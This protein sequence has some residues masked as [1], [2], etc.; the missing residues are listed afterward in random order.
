MNS[1]G[2]KQSLSRPPLHPP[3]P[4]NAGLGARVDKVQSVQ[5]ER[6]LRQHLVTCLQ[7]ETTGSISFAIE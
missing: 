4:A 3:P 7:V 2:S 6:Q 1:F 5:G